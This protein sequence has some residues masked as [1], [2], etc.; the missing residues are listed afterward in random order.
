MD[1]YDRDAGDNGSLI[2]TIRSGNQLGYFGI[3]ADK[4]V[5]RVAKQM[6]D[7]AV[8]IYTVEVVVTDRG[9]EPRSSRVNIEIHLDNS[10]P[11]SPQATNRKLSTR[12]I[13]L[14]IIISI[15]ASSFVISLILLGVICFI[16]KRNKR[17]RMR[18]AEPYDKTGEQGVINL[19][20]G[21]RRVPI[22]NDR[23]K[24]VG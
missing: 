21:A 12:A 23:V 13:N 17:R 24:A 14:Y 6:P 7:S 4:G 11:T 18:D 10:A 15:V 20:C 16:M 9:V 19:T 3:D 2:Y 1:A 22:C 8:G 5:I